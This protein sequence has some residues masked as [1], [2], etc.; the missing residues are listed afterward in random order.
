MFEKTSFLCPACRAPVRADLH[1]GEDVTCHACGNTY[2]VMIDEDSGRAALVD[3]ET[4]KAPEPLYLPRGSIRS[5]VTLLMAAVCWIRI[6]LDRPVPDW[7]F[8]LVLTIVGYYFGFRQ[9]RRKSS[10]VHDVSTPPPDEPLFLP[11]GFIRAF[12]IGGFGV[13]GLL[14]L[15][16]GGF[17]AAR[18]AEFYF[19]FSGLVLGYVYARIVRSLGSTDVSTLINHLKGAMVLGAAVVVAILVLSGKQVETRYPCMAL[20]TVVSFYFGS[21]S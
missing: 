9:T 20:A 3:T 5:L 1:D 18:Y 12:L 2:C 4:N 16:R 10:P 11:R 13:C 14:L 15:Q 19:I 17:E 8:S 7:L 21:R 6:G